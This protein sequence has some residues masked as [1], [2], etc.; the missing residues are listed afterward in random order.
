MV[1]VHVPPYTVEVAAVYFQRFW[2]NRSPEARQYLPRNCAGHLA[3]V[4]KLRF[5]FPAGHNGGELRNEIVARPLVGDKFLARPSGAVVIGRALDWQSPASTTD[6]HL[7][8]RAHMIDHRPSVGR[9]QS[10]RL[11]TS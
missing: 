7:P 10:F 1:I 4:C 5:R 11:M 2:A 9:P 3:I 8:D 6:A